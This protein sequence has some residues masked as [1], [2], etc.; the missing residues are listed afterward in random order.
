[1]MFVKSSDD[2]R[3]VNM[4]HI[5]CTEVKRNTKNYGKD[6]SADHL[7]A[8]VAHMDNGME[9]P[10][11]YGDHPAVLRERQQDIFDLIVIPNGCFGEYGEVYDALPF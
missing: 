7:Y 9:V 5:V 1:M 10:I 11:A 2:T 8:L 3:S 6:F 4:A